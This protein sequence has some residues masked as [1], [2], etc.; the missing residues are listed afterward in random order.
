MPINNNPIQSANLSALAAA[1]GVIK[2]TEKKEE[3]KQLKD[4]QVTDTKEADTKKADNSSI[5]KKPPPKPNTENTTTGANGLTTADIISRIYSTIFRLGVPLA[6]D[7]VGKEFSSGID[8]AQ[9]ELAQNENQI[10]VNA[11]S[12]SPQSFKEATTQIA[13]A[14]IREELR[15]YVKEFGEKNN[16]GSDVMYTANAIFEL[17]ERGDV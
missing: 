5:Q 17:I 15:K 13:V 4:S 6:S 7:F 12:A 9:Q 10:I 16:V 14:G 2:T 11:R 1:S 8:A 3:E